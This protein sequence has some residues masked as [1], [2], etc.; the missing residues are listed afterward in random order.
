MIYVPRKSEPKELDLNN[1]ESIAYKELE[2]AKQTSFTKDTKFTFEAYQHKNVKKILKEMFNG[3]CGYCESCINSISFEEVEHFRPKKALKIIGKKGL[4]Y[5]GYYWLAMKWENLL[6]ACQRCNRTHKKNHFPLVNEHK[7][8]KSPD[9]ENLE[10]P[11]LLNPCED[12][13]DEHL[14][15]TKQGHIRFKEGSL[16]GKTSIKIYGLYRQE[17]TEERAVLAKTLELL[18]EQIYDDLI[19]LMELLEDE[20]NPNSERKIDKVTL[21]ILKTYKL[22][23]FHVESPTR[24]FQAMAKQLTSDFLNKYRVSLDNLKEQHDKKTRNQMSQSVN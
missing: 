18:V 7:R 11:L 16:K 5:P 10:E 2:K 17:L 12:I 22:L 21:R 8:A 23:L 20:N 24:P 13:P 15:F 6:I 1:T 9:E 4:T 19:E 14:E 3:K